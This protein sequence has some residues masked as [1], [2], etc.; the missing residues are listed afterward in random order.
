[1]DKCLICDHDKIN[2]DE[3]ICSDCKE[4]FSS[5]LNKTNPLHPYLLLVKGCKVKYYGTFSVVELTKTY[6]QALRDRNFGLLY[7]V[8]WELIKRN[9][10]GDLTLEIS[11]LKF[12]IAGLDFS[13]LEISTLDT[14][15]SQSTSLK[16]FYP[17]FIQK[18]RDKGWNVIS[19]QQFVLITDILNDCKKFGAKYIINEY[20][21]KQKRV[22]YKVLPSNVTKKTYV[23]SNTKVLKFTYLF[24]YSVAL[25]AGVF[26]FNVV[27]SGNADFDV[28]NYI[29]ILLFSVAIAYFFNHAKI[30]K[31]CAVR[32]YQNQIV[33][34]VASND[35]FIDL[36]QLQTKADKHGLMDTKVRAIAYL[37]DEGYIDDYCLNLQSQYLERK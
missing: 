13:L 33:K 37:L 16:E 20:G 36:V 19:K 12:N 15:L 26:A 21:D 5:I 34:S 8:G 1:M 22:F 10:V 31:I 35:E 7:D 4:L 3:L 14:F 24:G 2:D 11:D 28:G 25:F 30:E 32:D 9:P 18:V 6:E 29:F 17:A 27:L 23:E